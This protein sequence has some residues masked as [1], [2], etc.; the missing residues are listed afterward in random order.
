MQPPPE[1]AKPDRTNAWSSSE[2]V[3]T[4]E[5]AQLLYSEL[6]SLANGYFRSQPHGHTLQPTVLVH[7]AFLKLNGPG[8][9]DA[10]KRW[11]GRAHFLAVAARAMRQILID[12]ARSKHTERRGGCTLVL[13]LRG[14]EVS[15][16]AQ[17][18]DVIQLNDAL[19]R[20]ATFD[21]RA[22][23]VVE[24]RFFAGM[25]IAEV[26]GVLGVSDW[27]VEEDWR[28]ARAWLA[29]QLGLDS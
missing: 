28:V 14:D 6:R 3:N 18:L 21:P 2:Q 8:D 15:G 9:Q 4:T 24:L 12:H 27:T 13:P 11:R 10:T 5:L 23:S 22:A 29:Q 20:L 19:E 7:E 16:S 26:A 17:P 25:S 1:P